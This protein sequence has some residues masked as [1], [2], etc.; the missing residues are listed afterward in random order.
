MSS[1]SCCHPSS[2]ESTKV[3]LLSDVL[4]LV[5]E[6]SR[7]KLLCILR[8]GDHCVC[9]MIEHLNMS[10]SLISHHLHD[11]RDANLVSDSKKGLRVYYSLTKKGKHITDLL[12]QIPTKEE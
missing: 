11:L 12:F 2:S 1:Y 7:L 5:S 3:S 9:E 8:Q 4:K 10:Q 6:A